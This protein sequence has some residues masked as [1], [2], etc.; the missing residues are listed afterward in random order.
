[1]G[2][3]QLFLLLACL[4]MM[5]GASQPATAH[6]C[7][8]TGNDAQSISQYNQCKADLAV[9]GMHPKETEKI[10]TEELSTLKAENKQLRLQLEIIKNRLF[11]IVKDL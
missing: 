11:E 3:R 10:A 1:M 5:T 8:L 4:G 9:S 6:L 7:T 2:I